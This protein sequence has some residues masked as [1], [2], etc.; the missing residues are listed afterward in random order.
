MGSSWGSLVRKVLLASKSIY[1]YSGGTTNEQAGASTDLG[2]LRSPS[3][4]LEHIAVLKPSSVGF[5]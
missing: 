3:E 2:Q 1:V 5:E 4:S